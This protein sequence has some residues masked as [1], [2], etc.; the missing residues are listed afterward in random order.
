MFLLL[1]L[2]SKPSS[3]NCQD[4][5][6]IVKLNTTIKV[7]DDVRLIIEECLNK[8][9][10]YNSFVLSRCPR[11]L[12]TDNLDEILS[13]DF[14]IGPAFSQSS[15]DKTPLLYFEFKGKKVFIN[16]GLEELYADSRQQDSIYYSQLIKRGVDSIIN[17]ANEIEKDGAVLYVHRSIYFKI[18]KDG[19]LYKNYRPDT[20]FLPKL[21]P[22][23]VKFDSSIK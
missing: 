19:S 2:C 8:Y 12:N 15:H 20:L 18:N 6:F 11:K 10:Q 23:T 14:L 5:D 22:A 1:V 9:P 4:N 13:N 7:R 16:C 3:S 21:L 17:A